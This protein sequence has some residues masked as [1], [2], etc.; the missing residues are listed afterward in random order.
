MITQQGARVQGSLG[1][2]D[3]MSTFEPTPGQEHHTHEGVVHAHRHFHVTHN[4]NRL[5]G[6]FDHL[7]SEHEHAH[8]HARVEHAHVPHQDF[9]HE[10]QGEAHIHDHSD[11]T[12]RE[13]E[14]APDPAKKAPAKKAA[15]KAAAAKKAPPAE[16]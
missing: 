6:G 16:S 13:L 1:R 14:A 12:N 10:H 4:H 9:D 8:D 15:K 3:G 7:W 11:P 2:E 5:T